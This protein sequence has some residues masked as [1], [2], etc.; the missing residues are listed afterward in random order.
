ML[1]PVRELPGSSAAAIARLRARKA[2]AKRASARRRIHARVLHPIDVPHLVRDPLAQRRSRVAAGLAALRLLGAAFGLHV[3]ALIVLVTA[4]RLV[5]ERPRL[6][7]TEPLKVH[8]VDMPPVDLASGAPAPAEPEIP[9][10]APEPPAPKAEP[11]KPEPRQAR[12]ATPRADEPPPAEAQP[13]GN[14]EPIPLIGLSLESTVSG[15]G[16]GFATGTSRMGETRPNQ[17]RG[18]ASGKPAAAMQGQGGSGHEQREATRIPTRDEK[19]EKPRRLRQQ[20]PAYPATLRAQGIEGSVMVSVSIDTAGVVQQASVIRGSGHAEFD[21]AALST[22]RA[23]RFAPATRNGTP[24][25]YTLSYS[26]HFRIE[27]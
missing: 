14:G 4:G 21:S 20:Q 26:Y 19:L 25:P 27:D 6:S 12:E 8:V 23:E 16:P 10:P 3:V 15:T 18:T 2:A 1:E 9:T 7:P 11:A 5:P 24:V 22:A 17:A 13:A